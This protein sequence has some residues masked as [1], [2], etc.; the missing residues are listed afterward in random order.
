MRERSIRQPSGA[1]RWPLQDQHREEPAVLRAADER[2]PIMRV[3]A[4]K[5]EDKPRALGELTLLLER[6]P[7]HGVNRGR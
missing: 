6:V 4:I 3:R 7:E 1:P 2:G 5:T